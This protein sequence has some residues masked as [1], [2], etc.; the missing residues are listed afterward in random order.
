MVGASAIGFYR[1]AIEMVGFIGEA[2]I[3][4]GNC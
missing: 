4:F 3:T 1:S 2:T